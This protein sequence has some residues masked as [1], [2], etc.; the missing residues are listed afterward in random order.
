MVSRLRRH[1]EK[2]TLATH[3]RQ[4]FGTRLLSSS[5]AATILTLLYIRVQSAHPGRFT[6]GI[7][8]LP[9]QV[10]RIDGSYFVDG[11]PA[12]QVHVDVETGHQDEQNDE[13]DGD[14]HPGRAAGRRACGAHNCVVQQEN[15]GCLNFE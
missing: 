1:G 8:L 6:G 12:R 2:K 7:L 10:L 13:D 3:V 14:H 4:F 15:S 9:A 5:C 11:A